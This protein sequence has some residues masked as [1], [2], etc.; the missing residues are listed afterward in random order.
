MG[1][2][3]NLTTDDTDRADFHGEFTAKSAKYAEKN[4]KQ[5]LA[6]NLALE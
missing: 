5:I 6:A 2:G 3:G 4:T 1:M